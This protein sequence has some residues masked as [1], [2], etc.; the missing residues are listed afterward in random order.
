MM[1]LLAILAQT[2]SEV[3]GSL[4]IITAILGLTTAMLA[5]LTASQNGRIKDKDSE[6]GR[7]TKQSDESISSERAR[8]TKA[9]EREDKAVD[10]A[11]KSA[12]LVQELTGALRES[13]NV[14]KESLNETRVVSSDTKRLIEVIDR[15]DRR[16][17][18][19]ERL[20]S[21]LVYRGGA[22]PEQLPGQRH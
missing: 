14:I 6:I 20:L 11:Q 4:G 8:T 10:S 3:S 2:G 12:T 7:L 21:Q 16:L 5:A 13:A 15:M 22:A 1:P 18:S 9:E 17:E 19:N